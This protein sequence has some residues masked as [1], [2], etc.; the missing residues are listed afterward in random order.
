MKGLASQLGVRVEELSD[1]A[2]FKEK[3]SDEKQKISKV[4]HDAI[5][6][7]ETF[8][9]LMADVEYKHYMH[10]SFDEVARINIKHLYLRVV[11][12]IYV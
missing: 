1:L 10:R 5:R 6:K 4:I 11:S 12:A 7:T 3:T 8:K 9:V 2:A